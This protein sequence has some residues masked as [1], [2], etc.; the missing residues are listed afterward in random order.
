MG[1]AGRALVQW[2]E[3]VV[4]PSKAPSWVGV[5]FVW[6]KALGPSPPLRN[7][8]DPGPIPLRLVYLDPLPKSDVVEG[9]VKGGLKWGGG[10]E[11]GF[12]WDP[13]SSEGPPMVP[14][15]GRP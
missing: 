12:G 14:A 8:S 2:F 15:E 4:R 1:A 10:G 9:G 3:V 13:P 5:H 11:G 6:P 7:D